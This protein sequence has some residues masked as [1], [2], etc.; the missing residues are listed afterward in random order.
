MN[1]SKHQKLLTAIY[2]DGMSQSVAAV[3]LCV[4]KQ[5][6]S[7]QLQ[8][9]EKYLSVY[10]KLAITSRTSRTSLDYQRDHIANGI[11]YRCGKNPI[12]SSG[13]CESCTEKRRPYMRSL[14]KKMYRRKLGLPDDAELKRGGYRPKKV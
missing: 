2:R 10:T 8:R 5:Y 4:S 9:F 14:A 7:A 1:V 6:I 13:M 12:K 11:C 3:I